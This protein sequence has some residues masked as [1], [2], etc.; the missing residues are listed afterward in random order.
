LNHTN[1]LTPNPASPASP[2]NPANPANPSPAN[3]VIQLSG[4]SVSNSNSNA[5]IVDSV[6][7]NK[8]GDYD[9]TRTIQA[10]NQILD[11]ISPQLTDEPVPNLSVQDVY[12]IIDIMETGSD[13]IRKNKANKLRSLANTA[14]L[15]QGLIQTWV[16]LATTL[17]KMIKVGGDH[18]LA[19]QNR[20]TGLQQD[21]LVSTFLMVLHKHIKDPQVL[22]AIA[23]DLQSVQANN[24]VLGKGT[25]IGNIRPGDR[26]STITNVSVADSVVVR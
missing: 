23:L 24:A 3:E 20:I 10:C 6:P 26:V 9:I 18:Y 11:K 2:A 5:V 16:L 22:A 4:S 13:T 14:A 19:Q 21:K 12:E 7:F 8:G 17:T 1:S 15:H 25:E